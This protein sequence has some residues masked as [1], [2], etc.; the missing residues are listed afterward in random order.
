VTYGPVFDGKQQGALKLQL[1]H[2]AECVRTGREPLI[3]PEDARAAV[4]VAEGIHKSL[5]TGERVMLR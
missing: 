5:E 1:E 3:S 2:F 4:A